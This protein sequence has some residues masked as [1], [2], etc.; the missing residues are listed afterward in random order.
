MKELL[1]HETRRRPICIG[2]Y[3]S[4]SEYAITFL[5]DDASISLVEGI[6]S[7]FVSQEQDNHQD[8]HITPFL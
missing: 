7:I 4:Y 5:L 3:P 1:F 8:W 6:F 2:S